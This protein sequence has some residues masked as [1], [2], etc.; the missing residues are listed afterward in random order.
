MTVFIN[1][2]RLLSDLY[3]QYQENLRKLLVQSTNLNQEMVWGLSPQKIQGRSY[4][5]HENGK[6]LQNNI[7]ESIRG[8]SLNSKHNDRN[9]IERT[10]SER[11]QNYKKCIKLTDTAKE[12]TIVFLY[13]LRKRIVIK[14]AF[15]QEVIQ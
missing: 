3:P 12:K 2:L 9:K 13:S 11:K 8:F 14:N 15:N 7:L 5:V 6:K 1:L 4:P 10:Y